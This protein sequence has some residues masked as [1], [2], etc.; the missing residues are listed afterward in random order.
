MD[1]YFKHIIP[2]VKL[3]CT[4]TVMLYNK[5]DR[6]EKLEVPD[7]VWDKVM[8]MCGV[9]HDLFAA[10]KK[11]TPLSLN[12]LLSSPSSNGSS[13]LSTPDNRRTTVPDPEVERMKNDVASMK[14][15]LAQLVKAATSPPAAGTRYSKGHPKGAFRSARMH[16]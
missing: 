16:S 9:P 10:N 8:K 12:P 15:M 4:D 11:G 13:P 1:K 6:D 14:A 5:F 7:R 3:E 2:A